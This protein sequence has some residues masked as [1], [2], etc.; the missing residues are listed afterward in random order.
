MKKSDGVVNIMEVSGCRATISYVPEL[1]R[2]RGRFLGLSGYC[3]FIADSI[4]GLRAEG[5]ISLREYLND[6]S[7]NGIEPY[8]QQEKQRTF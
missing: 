5:E 3:D 2:F 7:E 8:E 1:G 4:D 6:C